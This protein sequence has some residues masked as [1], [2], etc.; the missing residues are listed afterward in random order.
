[1]KNAK[2]LNA[3]AIE[4]YLSTHPNKEKL[5]YKLDRSLTYWRNYVK[6][7]A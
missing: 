3:E 1:M 6:K 2:F 5:M 4:R 7:S